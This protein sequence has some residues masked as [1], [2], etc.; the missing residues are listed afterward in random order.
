MAEHQPFER[1]FVDALEGKDEFFVEPDDKGHRTAR[2]TRYLVGCT[3]GYSFDP[4]QEIIQSVSF[5]RHCYLQE[6][7]PKA[8]GKKSPELP[9]P[10]NVCFFGE[11]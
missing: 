6:C 5:F 8:G 3:H 2:Y 9:G 1:P 4:Q 10:T 7:R 11:I